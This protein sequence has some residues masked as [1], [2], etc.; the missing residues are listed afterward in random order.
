MW[1]IFQ[2]PQTSKFEP[3]YVAF[4]GIFHKP[5]QRRIVRI[6]RKELSYSNNLCLTWSKPVELQNPITLLFYLFTLSPL[7]ILIKQQCHHNLHHTLLLQTPLS[8]CGTK[9]SSPTRLLPM[10]I[11]PVSCVTLALLLHASHSLITTA[12]ADLCW[13]IFQSHLH[14]LILIL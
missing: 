1:I 6:D 10:V 7:P 12:L 8:N 5:N 2:R 11:D 13:I 4:K 14:F 3:V 9:L